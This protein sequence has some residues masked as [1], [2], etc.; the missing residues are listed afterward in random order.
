YIKDKMTWAVKKMF[1]N[2]SPALKNTVKNADHIWCM[3]GSVAEVLNLKNKK[4]SVS[5][6]VAT[7]DF[8]FNLKKK[9][10]EFTLVSAGRFVPLKGFDLTILS[11]AKFL[12][13]L[14]NEKKKKCKLQL[15]GSGPELSY[16]KQ[17]CQEKNISQQV[18]FIDWIARE[19]LMK[20]FKES[21][22]FIFP[23]HEGAGMVVPE[24]L[25]FGLPVI[26]IDNCGPG[27]FVNDETAYKI[28]IQNF[29]DT[30]THLSAA[31][32]DLYS[33][34][35]KQK[36]MSKNARDLFESDFHW[37]RRGEKLNEIYSTL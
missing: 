1:W 27:S 19:E 33:N 31:I 2:L 23:S 7:A 3:N 37:D 36:M 4:Y 18:E 29:N 25:S 21:T 35:E 34:P 26:C 10:E 20:L 9:Q 11:F 22:A 28:S 13:T 24:A 32:L 14:S 17:L 12:K 30:V 6:S 16:L 5:A 15:V 8:G